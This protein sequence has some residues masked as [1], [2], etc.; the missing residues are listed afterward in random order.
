MYG[1][2]PVDGE[3][4]RGF[5]VRRRTPKA[6]TLICTDPTNIQKSLDRVA[7]IL[8]ASGAMDPGSSPGRDV[9][10]SRNCPNFI[11]ITMSLNFTAEHAENA[12]DYIP[13]IRSTASAIR[14]VELVSENLT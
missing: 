14:S 6:T 11:E 10:I 13:C 12:E 1:G 5:E 4:V 9:A 3:T 7:D 8:I 2:L